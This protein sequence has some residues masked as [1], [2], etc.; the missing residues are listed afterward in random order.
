M[1]PVPDKCLLFAEAGKESSGG[2]WT[3]GRVERITRDSGKMSHAVP[4]TPI[5]RPVFGRLETTVA[6]EE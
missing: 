3:R 4:G 5:P 6:T 2:C 1:Y